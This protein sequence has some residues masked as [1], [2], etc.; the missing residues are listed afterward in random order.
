MKWEG[1]GKGTEEVGKEGF[2]PILRDKGLSLDREEL[3][4]SRGMAVYNGKRETPMLG[5]GVGF[6]WACSLIKGA[7][8][9]WTS[10]L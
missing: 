10:I 4:C 7:F 2:C 3:K 5:L 1:K 8:D 9:C 6:N